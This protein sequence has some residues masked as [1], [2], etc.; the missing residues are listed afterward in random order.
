M[1]AAI[2]IWNNAK[3]ILVIVNDIT[4]LRH[5]QHEMAR[6][7][8][9]NLVGQ[10]AAEIGHEIRNPMTI[11]RGFLQ[12][13]GGKERYALDKEYM[14][15]LIEE[16]DR[17]NSI[18]AEFLSL[19]K[20][21]TVKLESQCLNKIIRTFFPLLQADALKQE[22]NIEMELGDIPPIVIDKNEII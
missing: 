18:I 14:D 17:V 8:R 3:C 11:V 4:E 15:L 22:K 1:P 6:L 12:L 16:L 9:L 5:Y 21:K 20:D 7:D 10:M 19:A 13:L 2:I